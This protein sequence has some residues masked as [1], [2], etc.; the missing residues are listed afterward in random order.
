M[1]CVWFEKHVMIIADAM[2]L[3]IGRHLPYHKT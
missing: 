2:M 3:S 1:F